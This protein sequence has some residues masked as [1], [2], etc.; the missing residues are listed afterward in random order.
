MLCPSVGPKLFWTRP[1]V[2][3]MGQRAEFST[4]Q[5]FLDLSKPIRTGPK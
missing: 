5:L 2:L 4:E 3:D 1:N